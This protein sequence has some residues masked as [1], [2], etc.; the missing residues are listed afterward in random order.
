MTLD[1]LITLA[2]QQAEDW[3]EFRIRVD[4]SMFAGGTEYVEAEFDVATGVV[5]LVCTYG[6]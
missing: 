5:T 3:S 1:E 6:P 2:E 4:G